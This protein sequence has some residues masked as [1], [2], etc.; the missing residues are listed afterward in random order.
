MTL[1]ECEKIILNAVKEK[2]NKGFKIISGTTSSPGPCNTICGLCA[3]SCLIDDDDFFDEFNPKYKNYIL[4]E[5]IIP[6]IKKK[7]HWLDEECYDFARG[8][9]TKESD[10]EK[11]IKNG[12]GYF[13]K[14]IFQFGQSFRKKLTENGITVSPEPDM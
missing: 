3:L 7:L 13:S 9:D 14:D 6:F 10:K 5:E 11:D 4:F 2:V 1:D 8:Y 12:V